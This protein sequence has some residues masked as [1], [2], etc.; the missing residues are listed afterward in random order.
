[1]TQPITTR[2]QSK[3]SSLSNGVV[4]ASNSF[5][6]LDANQ[7]S[8]EKELSKLN[9]DGVIKRFRKGIYYKPQKS[10]LFGDVLPNPSAIAQAIAK[11]N[12]AHIVPD[13]S[14]ALNML[15]LSDQVP[16]K[17]IYLND[18]LHKSEFVGN[19]EIVFKRINAKKLTTSNKRVGLV[20]SAI[21]YLGKDAFDDKDLVKDFASKLKVSDVKDLDMA[22]R[23]YPLWV[24][25]RVSEIINEIH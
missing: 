19:T 8:V 3:I 11:L 13:G 6:F 21:D 10:S 18:K 22:S 24:K 16:M 5:R 14:M 17:Y 23:Y 12:D 7:N 2:V 4:F 9:A 15:G 1:M 20:L 25:T